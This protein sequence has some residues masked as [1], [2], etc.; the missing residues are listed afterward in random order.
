ML[1]HIV[2]NYEPRTDNI[3]VLIC[4]MV[5]STGLLLFGLHYYDTITYKKGQRGFR[6]STCLYYNAAVWLTEVP[7]YENSYGVNFHSKFKQKQIGDICI[8][9]KSKLFNT[10]V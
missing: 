2:G 7:A 9:C 3:E 4:T 8:K 1:L 10:K 6:I 5:P